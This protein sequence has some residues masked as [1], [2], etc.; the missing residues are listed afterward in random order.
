M[1]GAYAHLT[2]VSR[3]RSPIFLENL[4]GFPREAIGKIMK[5]GKFCELG[6]VSP[7]YPYL[8]VMDSDAKRWADIM[9][10]DATG[11][12]L[13]AGIELVRSL[14]GNAQDKTLAW[15]LGFAAHVA[16]DVTIHP[17]VELKVGPYAENSTAHRVCEM[18]QDVFIFSGINVGEIKRAEFIDPGIGACGSK[19]DPHLLDPDIKGVW[20][21][22]LKQSSTPEEFM[23]N[24]PD[25]DQWHKWFILMVDK[26]GEELSPM[27]PFAR[28]MLVEGGVAYPRRDEL[29]EQYIFQL[30]TPHGKMDYTE[31]FERAVRSAGNLWATIA[32]GVFNNSSNYLTEI[33]NWDLDT[34]RR[35]D[36]VL[37]FWRA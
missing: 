3:L 21:E 2:L 19:D 36:G 29:D 23:S 10:Y 25:V 14:N 1:P 27:F 5:W 16:M 13:K 20:V 35:I 15:L 28:H 4:E 8:A 17:V 18:N 32:T 30:D 22:M 33:H 34:G 37:E 24:P 9:H 6:A 11:D 12:R 31:I 7:D 26:I